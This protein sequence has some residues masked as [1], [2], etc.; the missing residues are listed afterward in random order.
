MGDTELRGLGVAVLAF[1]LPEVWGSP[2]LASQAVHRRTD[3]GP[4]GHILL[5]SDL[6]LPQITPSI[7]TVLTK[8]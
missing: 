5:K 8:T 6:G 4:G 3:T 7:S 1:L 2:K